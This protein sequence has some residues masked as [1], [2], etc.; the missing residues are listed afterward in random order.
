MLQSKLPS[1]NVLLYDHLEPGERRLELKD[2][3]DA[4]T[5]K[6]FAVAEAALAAFGVDDFAKRFRKVVEQYRR[7]SGVCDMTNRRVLLKATTEH[8]NNGACQG[9]AAAGCIHMSQHWR[10]CCKVRESWAL[11]TLWLL[12]H[13]SGGNEQQTRRGGI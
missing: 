4:A 7:I 9:G 13:V 8:A 5:A 3:R 12:A 11:M 1:A 10:Q 2:A 6:E